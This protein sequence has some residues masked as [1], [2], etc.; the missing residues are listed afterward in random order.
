MATRAYY[1]Q[2]GEQWRETGCVVY[3]AVMAEAWRLNQ[4]LKDCTRLDVVGVVPG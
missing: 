2:G 1:G 4:E 3:S